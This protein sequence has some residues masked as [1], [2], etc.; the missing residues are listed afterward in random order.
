MKRL[1]VLLLLPLS[2][3]PGV[4][5]A[6]A[7]EPYVERYYLHSYE[8]FVAAGNLGRARQVAENAL[9]WRP[10][11]I[12][13]WQ[14]LAQIADWQGDS[15]TALRA[16]WKVAETTDDPQAW[17]QVRQRAPLAYDH[18]LTLRVYKELLETSPRDRDMLA[19]VARQYELL[20][21][22]P[23]GAITVEPYLITLTEQTDVFPIFQH[24]GLEFIYMLEGELAYRHGGKLYNLLP[25]DS[26]FFDSDAPHGPEDLKK[27]PIRFLSVIS[28]GLDK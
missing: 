23:H 18:Q 10:G 28:Y 20:G 13:W 15:A 21:H 12:R 8:V 11:D 5:L 27:L 17:Q 16:W 6:E 25:G 1:L 4:A 2:L 24:P 14:R 9:Y 3:F 22:A 19:T 26:L 7:P